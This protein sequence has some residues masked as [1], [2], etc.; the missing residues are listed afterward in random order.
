MNQPW[1]IASLLLV[2]AA[3]LYFAF[4]VYRGDTHDVLGR[5]ARR[6]GLAAQ[7]TFELRLAERLRS[8]RFVSIPTRDVATYDLG[9][10]DLPP[11]A[12]ATT[13]LAELSA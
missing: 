13:V 11:G 12:Y 5:F 1:L 3:L 4:R 2:A 10:F 6:T 8:A 9:D 7:E